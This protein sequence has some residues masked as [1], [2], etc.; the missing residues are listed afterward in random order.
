[1]VEVMRKSGTL[2]PYD[3]LSSKLNVRAKFQLN[4]KTD[5]GSNLT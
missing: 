3:A 5:G 2:Q 1:M 4:R